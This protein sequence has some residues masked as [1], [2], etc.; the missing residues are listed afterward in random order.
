MCVV[1]AK[2]EDEAEEIAYKQYLNDEAK[3]V[4]NNADYDVEVLH[5]ES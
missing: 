3:L 1:D 4:Y 5:A 2:N